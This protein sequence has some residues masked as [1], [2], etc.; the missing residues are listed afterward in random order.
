[1][2][3]TLRESAFSPEAEKKLKG[4]RKMGNEHLVDFALGSLRRNRGVLMARL[5]IILSGLHSHHH[6]RF[7]TS[8]CWCRKL[9]KEKGAVEQLVRDHI[10]AE[11]R[12]KEG[13][14]KRASQLFE[15]MAQRLEGSPRDPISLLFS[16]ISSI[17]FRNLGA[18]LAEIQREEAIQKEMAAHAS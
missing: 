5:G 8:R 18:K 4:G 9:E 10:L 12:L 11:D 1:M 3:E 17:G 7:C 14:L 15:E 13:N 16:S 6:S 2:A